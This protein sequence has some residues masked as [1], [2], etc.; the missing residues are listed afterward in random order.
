MPHGHARPAGG[1]WGSA[2]FAFGPPV[3]AFGSFDLSN[4]LGSA[5]GL[6]ELAGFF[7]SPQ[8]ASAKTS[9]NASNRRIT[10]GL[11][12]ARFALVVQVHEDAVFAAG[13]EPDV[14]RVGPV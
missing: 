6:G 8:P 4:I 1:S 9:A 11:R 2:Q 7:S 13:Q 12:W 3:G 10:S 5:R 14:V